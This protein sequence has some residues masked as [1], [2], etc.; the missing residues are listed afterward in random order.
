[1]T[2]CSP[3]F[4]YRSLLIV[5]IF[6]P[7]RSLWER[8][9]VTLFKPYSAP[10]CVAIKERHDV[11]APVIAYIRKIETLS[12]WQAILHGV[13]PDLTQLALHDGN[14]NPLF[15]WRATLEAATAFNKKDAAAAASG[16]V[17]RRAL[18]PINKAPEL[19]S[20]KD[21]DTWFAF[22]CSQERLRRTG[23]IHATAVA[24]TTIANFF[25]RHVK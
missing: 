9:S 16:E 7:Q 21:L 11:Y 22:L 5:K 15:H 14:I 8:A 1:M 20:F 13:P 2:L 3:A 6:F 25:Q 10:L 24:C 12:R 19:W 17:Y 4:D 23:K 18:A